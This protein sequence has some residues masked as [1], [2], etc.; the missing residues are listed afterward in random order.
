M[1][2][3]LLVLVGLVF[4][5]SPLTDPP[6]TDPAARGRRNFSYSDLEVVVAAEW[7]TADRRIAALGCV[8]R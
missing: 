7:L 5:C 2:A 4:G 1:R 3:V 8:T 6:L